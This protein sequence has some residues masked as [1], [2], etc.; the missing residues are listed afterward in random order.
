MSSEKDNPE[1]AGKSSS[2]EATP[3]PSTEVVQRRGGA[4]TW[5]AVLLALAAL[6]LSGWLAYPALTGLADTDPAER[7]GEI[8]EA[9]ATLERRVGEYGDQLEQLHSRAGRD[10]ERV[11]R[12]D[13]RLD[14]RLDSLSGRL[15]ELERLLGRIE[16]R[17]EPLPE[18]LDGLERDLANRIEDGRELRERL[19]AAVRQLDERGDIERQ[20]DR[21]LRR[22]VMMLEVASLLRSGQD[23]AELADDRQAALRAFRRAQARLGEI[24]DAR[25][26]R[27][28]RS[29]AGEIE[30]LSAADL[31][32]LDAELA[33]L[34]RLGRESRDWPLQVEQA[35]RPPVDADPAEEGWRQRLTGTFR[36]LVRIQARDEMGRTGEAFEA[37]REQ[38]RLRLVAAELALVRREAEPFRLQLGAAVEL[39]DDWFDGSASAV[40][41]AREELERL[42]RLPLTVELPDLGS[43]LEQLQSRLAES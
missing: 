16:E 9:L 15:G 17:T 43:A 5:F 18:R 19:E 10:L 38:L 39:L 41:A 13:E 25:L 35:G 34:E 29:L 24:E 12:M 3:A 6:G 30:E 32:D 33:L 36:S 14:E 37:A 2:G 23:L 11:D 20:V 26:D 8:R 40:H 7:N 22:Q 27:V 1:A 42:S 4:L 21:N 28:R 31:P